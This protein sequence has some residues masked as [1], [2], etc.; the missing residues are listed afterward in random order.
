MIGGEWK[1]FG[2]EQSISL[3][4][5]EYQFPYGSKWPPSLKVYSPPE[6]K[7]NP[8]SPST[9]NQDLWGLGCIIWEVFNGPLQQT[10]DLARIGHIPAKLAPVYKVIELLKWLSG[11]CLT[12]FAS[13]GVYG[14]QSYKE[15]KTVRKN[16]LHEIWN[17][18][19]QKCPHRDDA[20]SRG[21]PGRFSHE[22]MM[23][24]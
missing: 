18:I 2:L 6:L 3:K 8:S 17:R 16:N 5:E 22:F 1:I 20:F 14:S 24:Y 10:A 9:Q 13:L 21:N 4:G 15:T 11:S 7:S 19:L 23:A 12:F